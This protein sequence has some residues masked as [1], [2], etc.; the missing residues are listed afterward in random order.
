M[1]VL[2]KLFGQNTDGFEKASQ[3]SVYDIPIT[4]IDGQRINLG[5]FRGKKI[6]FV[7][8]ASRCGFTSQY[9]GL[10]NLQDI[11]KSKLVVIGLPCNQFA[12]QE[13]GT[14]EEIK[15][16]CEANYGI[17]FQL[18]E[19]I[20]VKGKDQHPLYEWLTNKELNGVKNSSVMW[21]F[22]KYLVDENGQLIDFF[23]SS[24]RPMSKSITKYF[25]K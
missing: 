25:T 5:K 8:V 18:T 15:D 23:Y 19:K 14:T 20:K 24:T 3:S 13:P 7:N 12:N 21:N 9:M 11:F 2:T 4:G 10:Q 1:N 17:N 6:L 16:F 22:Q